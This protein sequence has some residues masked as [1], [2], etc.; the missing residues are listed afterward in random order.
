MSDYEEF[1]NGTVFFKSVKINFAE[2]GDF[3]LVA[4]INGIESVPSG[5][6]TIVPP[7]PTIVELI[8]QSL[9]IIIILSV[10]FS[11]LISSHP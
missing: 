11:V 10:V 9:E 7:D 1:A 8:Q 4:I 3:M 6:I 2:L 5:K